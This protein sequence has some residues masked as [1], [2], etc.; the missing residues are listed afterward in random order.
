MPRFV[1][2]EE[3]G[4]RDFLQVV[5][6]ERPWPGPGQL[7]VRVMAAG[8]NPMDYKA[9]RDERSAGR[10]GVTLPSGIG[11]D[12]AGYVE[13]VGE[14]VTRFAA[15]DAVFG[16]APFAAVA[17]FVVVSEEGQV[18]AKPEPLTFEVAGS[19]GVVGRTAMAT[20]RSLGLGEHDTVLVSAAAGGVGV[21]AAQLAVRAGATVVGTAG[22]ENHE[23]LETLGVIPVT[24]GD[25][26]AERVRDLLD[27]DRV[28]AALDNHGGGTIEAALELGV[29][30]ERINTIAVFG[31]DAHGAQNVGGA[32]AGNDELAEL[33]SLLAENELVL[34]IDSIYPIERTGEAY[35]RLEAGHLRGKIVVVTD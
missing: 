13:D 35:G 27:G 33:A 28:T 7:L 15:G 3:F 31:P 24:Y 25:G 8:L 21:L 17:D 23:F 9:Y 12:F 14:G 5:E 2:F 30:V 1:Q 10:M 29:P 18:V 19:L 22:E 16:T 34:P 26:L 11:Q 32:S 20:T 6:R 4:S